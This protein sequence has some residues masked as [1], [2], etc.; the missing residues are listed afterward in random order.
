MKF[1]LDIFLL[2]NF[3]ITF[4]WFLTEKAWF[5]TVFLI[6]Q[7]SS[8]LFCC[9]SVVSNTQQLTHWNLLTLFSSL[10]TRLFFTLS[11]LP[12]ILFNLN[13][14][15]SSFPSVSN[16]L[17]QRDFGWFILRANKVQIAPAPSDPTT[18]SLNS[19]HY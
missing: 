7:F 17:R 14:I 6:S 1:D 13:S 19:P 11:L 16:F 9:C 12:F 3:K 18:D 2:L 4:S 8:S 15:S 10:L 5:K